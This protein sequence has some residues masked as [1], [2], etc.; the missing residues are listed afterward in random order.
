MLRAALGAATSVQT[1]HFLFFPSAQTRQMR[2]RQCKTVLLFRVV[3]T[4]V[5]CCFLLLSFLTGE[6]APGEDPAPK[7]SEHAKESAN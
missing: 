6:H 1:L 3:L 4:V 2:M 7:R 5:F